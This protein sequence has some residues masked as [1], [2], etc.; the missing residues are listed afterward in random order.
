MK[1]WI[2]I[3]SLFLFCATLV[4]QTAVP[5]KDEPSHH[6]KLENN[7][8]RVF[9]VVVPQNQETLFHI[10]EQDYAFVSLGD[11]TLKA[12]LLG[13][14]AQDLNLKDGE[15]RFT[16]GPITH[17]VQNVGRQS[18]HNITIEILGSP[19]TSNPKQLEPLDSH[20]SIV[21]ENDRVRIIRTLLKAGE[22]T[23]MH[24]HATA[25]LGIAISEGSLRV[26]L[27]GKESQDRRLTPGEFVW[28]DGPL[29]HSLT[30]TGKTLYQSIDIELK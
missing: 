25:G 20:Q 18:F 22:S 3:P 6:L 27:E 14:P 2:R 24:R 21:L 15:V 5:V 17:R 12:Q 8:V 11:A 4:A 28:R 9:D 19:S 29:T 23:G 16:R 13:S 26:L 30:N 7:Q 10:H 1:A